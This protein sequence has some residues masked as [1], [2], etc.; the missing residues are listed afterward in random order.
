MKN[1]QRTLLAIVLAAAS[2]AFGGD[3]I[4]FITNIKGEISVD[5]NAR[6]ALLAEL[7]R[8][9]KIVVGR[10][11]EASVM[12]IQSG[13]EYVLPGPADY[14]VKD[15][16]IQGSVAMPPR[17]R[18][19]AW[20]ASNKVLAQ[21]AQTSAASVRMRSIGKP[22]VQEPVLIFPTQGAVASLQPTLRWRDDAA[23]ADIMIMALGQEKPLHQAKAASG[24][25]RIP[26]RLLAPDSE[27]LWTV[28][29]AGNELGAGKFRTLSADALAQIEQRRPSDRAQFSDRLLFAL[30]LQEMGAVQ[31]ARES[32]ARLAQERSDLPELASFAK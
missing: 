11:S 22:K 26:A 25:Y 28:T 32:W 9:Q 19:T 18:E 10:N 30:M 20:R 13:K 8:G 16:E 24:S 14:T 17:T 1:V 15:N 3:G 2:T 27:Y 5:G 4:A 12:Y 29:V 7:G 21:V 6:P 31:E 23:K